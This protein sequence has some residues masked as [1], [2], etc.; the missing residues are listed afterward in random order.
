MK[1]RV[2]MGF[3]L[4]LFG[5][6]LGCSSKGDRTMQTPHSTE[7]I[8][9]EY[10]LSRGFKQSVTDPDI[11]E[12]ENVR[13]VDMAHKLGFSLTDLLPTSNQAL[14]SDERTVKI[15][16]L[17]FL[18]RSEVRDHNDHIIHGSLDNPD[19]ICTVS[20]SVKQALSQKYLVTDS[21]P[22]LCI[23]AVNVAQDASKSLQISFEL[24][25]DGKKPL[26]VYQ[27]QFSV[28][29][30]RLNQ[31]FEFCSG[32]ILFPKETPQVI[33]VLPGKPII[34]T[35]IAFANK[36]TD[37]LWNS[38]PAGEYVLSIEIGGSK[39]QNYD[40]QWVSSP[41]DSDKYQLFIQ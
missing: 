31:P 8:T 35:V 34:I 14:E 11:F 12:A 16:D 41:V 33:T 1:H 5:M 21:F 7:K 15:K 26:A 40:Y 29:L 10:L 28:H 4:G 19:A 6:L 22:G 20:V 17:E 13:V 9:R 2:I 32:D 25:A 39:E 30:A 18:V 27:S 37:K 36:D 23:K 38:L 24:F 3:L